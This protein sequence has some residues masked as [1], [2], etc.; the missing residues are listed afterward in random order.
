MP[1]GNRPPLAKAAREFLIGMKLPAVAKHSDENFKLCGLVSVML[2]F[3]TGLKEGADRAFCSPS[4]SQLAD[5]MHCSRPTIERMM[6]KLR[7]CGT[8]S[9]LNRG[10]T[11]CLYTIHKTPQQLMGQAARS[12]P[13]SNPARSINGVPSPHQEG[14][15][16]P[17]T[18]DT[19]WVSPLEKSSLGESSLVA[20][21]P[22]STPNEPP[23]SSNSENQT[24]TSKA[25]SLSKECEQWQRLRNSTEVMDAARLLL[26]ELDIP[27]GYLVVASEVLCYAMKAENISISGAVKKIRTKALSDK[28]AGIAMDVAY[29]MTEHGMKAY[30][31]CKRKE[32]Q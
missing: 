28:S 6:R 9:K 19:H 3:A 21:Q 10:R 20:S 4:Q 11:S 7:E 14:I 13:S 16:S 23:F 22:T 29:L 26:H 31:E 2:L 18:V 12:D 8:L 32:G 1:T 15:F 30:R 17:S 27:E 25:K 24:P 5:L